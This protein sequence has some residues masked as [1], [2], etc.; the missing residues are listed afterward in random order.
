MER[1]R[2]EEEAAEVRVERRVENGGGHGE[3]CLLQEVNLFM[4]SSS[5]AMV[6][7]VRTALSFSQ[8]AAPRC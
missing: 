5:K 6:E 1:G 2:G 7:D 3:H 8:R 4:A